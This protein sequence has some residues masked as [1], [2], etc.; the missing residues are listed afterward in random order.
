M[1][2]ALKEDGACLPEAKTSWEAMWMKTKKVLGAKAPR[3]ND[4]RLELKLFPPVPNSIAIRSN[5]V[6]A[7]GKIDFV[8]DAMI[9]SASVTLV[10]ME[11]HLKM[12]AYDELAG[13]MLK[14]ALDMD[15]ELA[16]C[17]FITDG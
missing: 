13:D 12:E 9:W 1:L 15:F 7:V 11:T 17:K 14:T 3:A 10:G 16:G 4:T 2:Q 5:Y 8:V 6:N